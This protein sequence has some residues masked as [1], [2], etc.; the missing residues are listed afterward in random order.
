MIEEVPV[1]HTT[2]LNRK[3]PTVGMHD[4]APHLK[5]CIH[6]SCN[7]VISWSEKCP[8]VW[9]LSLCDSWRL[10]VSAVN[11]KMSSSVGGD[12]ESNVVNLRNF[13]LKSPVLSSLKILAYV[14]CFWER[15]GLA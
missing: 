12:S 6:V 7:H 2:T 11:L 9:I 10:S 4:G 1:A 13:L 3:P 8:V 15:S 5:S 14:F